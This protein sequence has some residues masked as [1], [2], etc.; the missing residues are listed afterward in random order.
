MASAMWSAER[1]D[2]IDRVYWIP[3][4]QILEDH[5]V[6]VVLVNAAHAKM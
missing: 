2:G 1:G 6:D 4:C 5:Q 3:V